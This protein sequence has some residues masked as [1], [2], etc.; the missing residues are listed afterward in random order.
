MACIPWPNWSD[1]VNRIH[2]AATTTP[3]SLS[4]IRL[5]PIALAVLAEQGLSPE[6]VPPA[7][8]T[9]LVRRNANLSTGGTAA[10]V[11]DLV[12]PDVAARSH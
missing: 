6:A 10:D 5:C 8:V 7:G 9:V 2:G 4:K 1:A 11:T 12:H 3:L